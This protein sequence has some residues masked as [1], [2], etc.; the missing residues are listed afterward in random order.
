VQGVG[1]FK[2]KLKTDAAALQFET[3]AADL[4]LETDAT[5]LELEADTTGLELETNMPQETSNQER[6]LAD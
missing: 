2:S 4:K 3:S 1:Y 5:A 6:Y